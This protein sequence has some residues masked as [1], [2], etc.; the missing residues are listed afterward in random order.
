MR[1]AGRDRENIQHG[2]VEMT[3]YGTQ[4]LNPNS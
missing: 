4:T 1:C 3:D 2:F